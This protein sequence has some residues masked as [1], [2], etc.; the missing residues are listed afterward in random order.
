MMRRKTPLPSANGAAAGYGQVGYGAPVGGGGGGGY[1]S[2]G[3]YGGPQGGGAGGGALVLEGEQHL[4][5]A[6]GTKAWNYERN[7]TVG[8][9]VWVG[10]GV[11]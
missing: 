6:E 3:G 5:M 7:P 11:G 9:S 8:Q 4:A 1:G 10:D 2:Q